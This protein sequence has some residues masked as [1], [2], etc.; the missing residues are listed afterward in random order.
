MTPN[1]ERLE[2]LLWVNEQRP[3]E[4]IRMKAWIYETSP[5]CGTI[6][7]IV[8]AGMMDSVLQDEGLRP[9]GAEAAMYR[10]AFGELRGFAAIREFFGLS[11]HEARN[12]FSPSS[13]AP[14]EHRAS[15]APIHRLRAFIAEHRPK[16]ALEPEVAT[17]L[18]TKEHED[19]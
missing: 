18:E 8:G 5:K 3:V 4:N 9:T 10:P 17:A 15:L 7:C 16:P 6:G 11:V 2:R 1:I 12:L 19:A 14:T 13:Y